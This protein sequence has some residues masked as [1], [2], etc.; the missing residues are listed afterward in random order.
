MRSLVFITIGIFFLNACSTR[1]R[2]YRP[3]QDTYCDENLIYLPNQGTDRVHERK[4]SPDA[5][6]SENRPRGATPAHC[7]FQQHAGATEPATRA[8]QV[9]KAENPAH[10]F[11]L[12]FVELGEDGRLLQADQLARLK[13]SLQDNHDAGKRNHVI[14]FVHGWRH[15]ADLDNANVRTFRTLLNY[16]SSFVLER[17]DNAVVTGV[18]VGW[19]GRSFPEPTTRDSF[20]DKLW[21]PFAVWTFAKRKKASEELAWRLNDL[22]ERISAKLDTAPSGNLAQRDT[23]VVVGHSFGGNMIATAV[24]E[25]IRNSLK[26]HSPGQEFVLPYSDLIVLINPAAEASKM[27][28]LQRTIRELVGLP[29]DKPIRD[30]SEDERRRFESFFPITQPPRYISLTSTRNWSRVAVR[31][32]ERP[33]YDSA[34]G[35][36]FPIGQR[37]FGEAGAER[38]AIGHHYPDYFIAERSADDLAGRDTENPEHRIPRIRGSQIG[39]SHDIVTISGAGIKTGFDNAENPKYSAC[40]RPQLPWLFEARRIRIAEGNAFGRSWDTAYNH[41]KARVKLL[42]W[43]RPDNSTVEV[44]VRHQ[45]GIKLGPADAERARPYGIAGTFHSVAPANSPIWIT[46]AFDNVITNHGGFQNYAMWCA[47]SQMVLDDVAARAD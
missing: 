40:P 2:V 1:D 21:L 11:N 42:Q 29:D 3:H 26:Q 25:P 30:F 35:F 34:T 45:V 39:A 32:G 12:A 17:D 8:H 37:L 14:L 13:K 15:D 20:G 46:R 4:L 23:F 44:Q 10:R 22:L 7:Y 28:E 27:N 19:R 38:V 31:D 47:L 16:S 41:T 24:K 36:W 43:E 6:V 9:G 33:K 18:Y 5:L